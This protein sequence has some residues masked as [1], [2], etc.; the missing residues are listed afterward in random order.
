MLAPVDAMTAS[1]ALMH[2]SDT[3]RSG[4]LAPYGKERVQTTRGVDPDNLHA[5][6][7]AGFAKN[8]GWDLRPVE[9]RTLLA[10]G[11]EA[12]LDRI[13]QRLDVPCRGSVTSTANVSSMSVGPPRSSEDAV[14]TA[15]ASSRST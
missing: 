10:R 11:E 6:V 9:G 5:Q 1:I 2:A 7:F 14:D 4:W 8:M 15:R 13:L 3:E 12:G